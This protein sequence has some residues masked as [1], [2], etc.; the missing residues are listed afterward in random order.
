MIGHSVESAVEIWEVHH[1]NAAQIKGGTVCGQC[2]A[3]N[4][5]QA[6]GPNPIAWVK[7]IIGG[8]ETVDRSIY[9]VG[10][11]AGLGS[12]ILAPRKERRKASSELSRA[13]LPRFH[14]VDDAVTF[15]EKTLAL[16][17]DVSL[18][19]GL[20]GVLVRAH[21]IGD[22]DGGTV[23][24]SDAICSVDNAFLIESEALR[25]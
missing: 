21:G 9:S 16:D 8:H 7:D 25:G 4:D 24:N 18:R 2:L 14:I 20:A 23:S 22:E 12:H 15:P 17:T 5:L 19:L 13:Q 6:L 3:R 10:P 11:F 1:R